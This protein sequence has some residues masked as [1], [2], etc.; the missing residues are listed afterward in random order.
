SHTFTLGLDVDLRWVVVATQCDHGTIAPA[1]KLTRAQ[2]ITWVQA[3]VRAGHTVHTVYECCG[4][5]YTLHEQL[6]AAGAQSLITT[7]MRLNLER[8]RKNDRLD[9]RELCVRLSR[10]LA[11]QRHELRPIRIPSRAETQRR[12]LGRQREFF[13]REVRRL[14]NHGRALRIEHEH[15]TLPAGWA[16]P[17]KWKQLSKECSAFVRAQLEPVAHHIRSL[18]AELDRLT[19]QLEALVAA[20]AIP[21]GLGTLTVAL[22]DGEVCDWQRFGHRKAIGSYTGCCPSEHS[23]SSVQRF[24]HIDRHGNARVRVLLVEAV[25]RL[26]KWQPGWHARQ[27]WLAKLKHGASLKKKIAVALARQLAIDLWRWRTGR[28]TAA[29][30]GWTLRSAARETTA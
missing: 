22:L 16:G 18:K 2:L 14:E 8:R 1:R 11:G 20:E 23:S 9:A 17:R 15:E 27:K 3:Q 5:G 13:K 26:L 21:T 6:S 24:G 30:L 29:E 25:W 28:A 12:E 10:Y 19:H 7:P 4:F